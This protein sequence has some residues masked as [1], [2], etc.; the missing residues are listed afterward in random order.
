MLTSTITLIYAY[1]YYSLFINIWGV[2][3]GCKFKHFDRDIVTLISEIKKKITDF[4]HDWT[5][6]VTAKLLR[7]ISMTFP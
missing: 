2:R 1:H 6:R 3:W 4:V 7:E 5:F